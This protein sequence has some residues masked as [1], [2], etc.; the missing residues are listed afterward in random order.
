MKLLTALISIIVITLLFTAIIGMIIG[1]ISNSKCKIECKKQ[2]ALT[3][4][5][6]AS[7]GYSIKEDICICIFRDEINAFKVGEIEW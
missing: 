3:S 4:D 7:G 1:A 6:V 5:L 2:G